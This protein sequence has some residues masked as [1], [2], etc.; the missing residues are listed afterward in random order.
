VK[1]PIHVL[2]DHR[3]GVL[4]LD[5]RPGRLIDTYL[6]A[7]GAADVDLIL[8][9]FSENSLVHSP[10]YGPTPARTFYPKLFSDTSGAHLTLLATMRGEDQRGA[11]VISFYFHFDWRLS[12]GVATSF[13]VV[14]VARLGAHGLIDEL[15][16]VYDTVHVRPAFEAETGRRSWRPSR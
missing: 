12:S 2:V 1:S 16:I 5:M 13:D 10:L 7:L 3:L 6:R 8:S 9:V 14:D 15:H 4:F 11:V